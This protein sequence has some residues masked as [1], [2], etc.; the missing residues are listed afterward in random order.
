MDTN[1]YRKDFPIFDNSDLIYLDSAATSQKPASVIEAMSSY[2]LHANANPHRGLYSLSAEATRLYERG[3]K[4]FASFINAGDSR[5]IVF[6]RN[7]T[8]ALNLVALSYATNVLGPEDEVVIPISEHHSNLVPWQQVCKRTGA[9]LVY[10]LV[11]EEGDI[12]DEELEKKITAKT[13]IVSF[14]Q[15]GNVLGLELPSEKLITQ[16]HAV[17]AVAI[18]D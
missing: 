12:D 8:E 2:Y 14:A 15:V 7:A 13:K 5:Q 17:G 10:L 9:Q 1:P 6:V 11:N 18:V 16:A 3:R 4:D